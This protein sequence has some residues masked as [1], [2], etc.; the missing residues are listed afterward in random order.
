MDPRPKTVVYKLEFPIEYGSE[1]ITHLTLRRP[2]GKDLRLIREGGM[3]ET[4]D[5]IARLAGQTKPVVD[6]LDADDVE[7][8]SKIIKGF[9]RSGQATG[10][11]QPQS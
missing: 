1:T 3:A 4:L 2:R 11:E 9:T 5:L 8:V 6:E 7:E 10:G